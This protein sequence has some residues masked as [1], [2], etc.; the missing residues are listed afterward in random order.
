MLYINVEIIKKL[1]AF[2]LSRCCLIEEN[3]VPFKIVLGPIAM[4]WLLAPALS[5]TLLL[6]SKEEGFSD[7]F[8]S[9]FG[10]GVFLGVA[11]WAWFPQ[12]EEW[13]IR[14]LK[15][16]SPHMGFDE[17]VKNNQ[18]YE[19]A[20]FQ[21][22]VFLLIVFPILMLP[23]LRLLNGELSQQIVNIAIA[24]GALMSGLIILLEKILLDNLWHRIG[25][26]E[27]N[28]FTISGIKGL[29]DYLND[30]LNESPKGK[31]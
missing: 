30:H 31:R 22:F 5:I 24:I 27:N 21:G 9:I 17:K 11:I 18:P 1:R 10:Y 14:K 8:R 26:M 28:K 23:Y 2:L 3:Y 6:I 16:F 13:S 20:L 29:A 19:G 4:V 25:I 15:F 7:L 12:L